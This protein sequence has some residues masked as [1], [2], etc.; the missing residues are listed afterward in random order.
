MIN[1]EFK[2]FGI[3]ED[4]SINEMIVKYYGHN[5]LKQFKRGKSIQ[6]EYKFGLSVEVAAKQSRRFDFRIK[7]NP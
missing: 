4:L 1:V 5:S 7:S 2:K 3:F 6:F